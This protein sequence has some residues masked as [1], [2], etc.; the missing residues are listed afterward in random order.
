MRS[1]SKRT[2][3]KNIADVAG[4][5][6]YL[7]TLDYLLQHQSLFQEIIVTTDYPREI[8]NIPDDITYQLREERLCGDDV[9]TEMVIVESFPDFR[10]EDIVMIF[11]VTTPFRNQKILLDC[12]EYFLSLP[13]SQ[14]DGN[15]VL[16]VSEIHEPLWSDG[17]DYYSRKKHV[18]ADGSIFI[19]T[20][21]FLRQW[22][23]FIHRDACRFLNG[24]IG[25]LSS[26]QIDTYDQYLLCTKLTN[27]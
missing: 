14:R 23:H 11:Q 1:G 15:S 24:P 18:I 12:L 19:A 17:N 27:I 25:S 7:H 4:K 8:L 5:E 13:A 3:W 22:N 9:K 16:T 2:P 10:D 6:M 20:M 26:L 21:K